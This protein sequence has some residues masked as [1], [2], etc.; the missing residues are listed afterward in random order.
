MQD[1]PPDGGPGGM[2]PPA[3]HKTVTTLELQKLAGRTLTCK[4]MVRS[5]AGGKKEFTVFEYT[6]N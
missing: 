1:M 4:G 3:K 2:T 5:G 6:V